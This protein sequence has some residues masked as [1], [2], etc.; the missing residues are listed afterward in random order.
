MTDFDLVE[1]KCALCGG[2]GF[3]LLEGCALT[4][5]ELSLGPGLREYVLF[6]RKGYPC[7]CGLPGNCV[8]R[9]PIEKAFESLHKRPQPDVEASI[10]LLQSV[11]GPW[12]PPCCVRCEREITEDGVPLGPRLDPDSR[13]ETGVV[14]RECKTRESDRT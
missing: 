10:A 2:R 4:D 3:R 14:C 7:L 9:L 1:P 5:E 8:P 11:L 12:R 13:T 6:K